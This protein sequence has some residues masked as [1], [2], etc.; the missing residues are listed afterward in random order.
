V[1]VPGFEIQSRGRHFTEL[2]YED[3]F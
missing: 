2:A 1:E 3:Y